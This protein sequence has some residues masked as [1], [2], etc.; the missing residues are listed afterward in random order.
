MDFTPIIKK[1][2]DFQDYIPKINL[3]K[4]KKN[5]IKIL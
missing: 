5:F 3:S 2:K 4:N 1:T